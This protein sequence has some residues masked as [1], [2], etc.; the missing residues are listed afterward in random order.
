MKTSVDLT[1]QT[2]KQIEDLKGRTGYTMA[3]VITVAVDRMHKQEFCGRC[4]NPLSAFPTGTAGYDKDYGTIC[5]VCV[6]ESNGE[7]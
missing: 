7:Y 6:T 5:A 2:R 3:T 4:G 1:E